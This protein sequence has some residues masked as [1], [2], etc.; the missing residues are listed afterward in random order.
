MICINLMKGPHHFAFQSSFSTRKKGLQPW[1]CS[2]FC[3]VPVSQQAKVKITLT[4]HNPKKP[5]ELPI[6]N[7]HINHFV[8]TE[9]LNFQLCDQSMNRLPI[10]PVLSDTSAALNSA[11]VFVGRRARNSTSHTSGVNVLHYV[12]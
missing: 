1:L 12:V 8:S 6:R 7:A 3:Q 4:K 10:L 2:N 5:I 9:W 11:L